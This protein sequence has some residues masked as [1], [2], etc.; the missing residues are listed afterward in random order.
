M[1]NL[2][3]RCRT[4]PAKDWSMT[5]SRDFQFN[6]RRLSVRA[7]AS[8]EGWRIG[9]LEGDRPVTAEY[10]VAHAAATAAAVGSWICTGLVKGLMRLAQ[11]D[12]ER[13]RLKLAD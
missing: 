5:R 2:I 3:Y 1:A 7:I 8:K 10:A 13:R 11:N 9:V 4:P 6:D 12:V